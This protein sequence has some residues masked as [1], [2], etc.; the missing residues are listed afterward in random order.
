MAAVVLHIADDNFFQ[1]EPGVSAGDHL[2]SGL[3]PLGLLA[4]AAASYLRVRPG[5]RAVIAIVTGL[6]GLVMGFAEAG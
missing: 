2:V 3:V 5:A 1:P 4:L 6:M